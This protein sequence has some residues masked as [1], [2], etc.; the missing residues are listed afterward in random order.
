MYLPR[1]LNVRDENRGSARGGQETPRGSY[2]Q[3]RGVEGVAWKS[4]KGQ[5]SRAVLPVPSRQLALGVVPA[6]VLGWRE[7]GK[8]M[9]ISDVGT[10]R[11]EGMS[12]RISG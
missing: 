3:A 2:S 5:L 12:Q 9:M 11:W 8:R 10:I 7:G 4:G 1:E 6:T